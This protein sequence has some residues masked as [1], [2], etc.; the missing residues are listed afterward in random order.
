MILTNQ[1]KYCYWQEGNSTSTGSLKMRDFQL[2]ESAEELYKL[3][4]DETYGKIAYY[5]RVKKQELHSLYYVRWLYG[6]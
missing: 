2:Y 1:I 5:G 4:K 6:G 3:T